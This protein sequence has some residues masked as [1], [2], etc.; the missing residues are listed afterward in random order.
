MVRTVCHWSGDPGTLEKVVM[1][2]VVDGLTLGVEEKNQKALMIV[3]LSVKKVALMVKFWP[4][5]GQMVRDAVEGVGHLHHAGEQGQ[6]EGQAHGRAPEAVAVTG[7]HPLG[8]G[9]TVDQ[10]RMSR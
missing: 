10:G 9:E 6:A 5:T 3:R 8:T 7:E 1:N 2:L 4:S